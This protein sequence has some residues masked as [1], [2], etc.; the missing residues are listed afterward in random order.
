MMFRKAR[1]RFLVGWEDMKGRGSVCKSTLKAWIRV[2]VCRL[3]RGRDEL[4]F[5][6]RSAGRVSGL[7]IV[8]RKCSC[9]R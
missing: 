8:S 4:S 3:G 5:L 2:E 6:K 1:S 9:A 7:V